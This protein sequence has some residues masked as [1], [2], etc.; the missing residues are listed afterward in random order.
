M[1]VLG[2]GMCSEVRSMREGGI[3]KVGA[4]VSERQKKSDALYC[5]QYKNSGVE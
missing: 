2:L 3:V 1:R 4:S 5:H